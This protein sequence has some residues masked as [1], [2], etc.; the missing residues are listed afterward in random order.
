M[1][2]RSADVF[3]G[4]PYNISSYALLTF[5]F[6]KILNMVPGRYIHTFGDVHI[7]DDHMD[8]V[9]E[10]LGNNVNKYPLP[11]LAFNENATDYIERFTGENTINGTHDYD[12]F[13]EFDN[14]INMIEPKDIFLENY[15]SFKFI[16]AKLSTG[17]K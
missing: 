12:Y 13:D 8:Q 2:Q 9:N 15:Q 1:Y 3:L 17:L 6:A 4:V 7:Y 14:F 11:T 5:F 16:K 10:I